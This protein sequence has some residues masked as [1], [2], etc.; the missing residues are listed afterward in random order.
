MTKLLTVLMIL[1]SVSVACA[2]E[3]KMKL[4]GIGEV[5]SAR[6][7]SQVEEVERPESLK[8]D[9]PEYKRHKEYLKFIDRHY[10]R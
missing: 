3:S 4:E 9:T 5:A 10:S 6:D 8:Y 1:G 7:V 2:S